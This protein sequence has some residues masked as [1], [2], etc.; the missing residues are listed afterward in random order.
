MR[1]FRR[2]FCTALVFFVVIIYSCSSAKNL[3]NE[4]SPEQKYRIW[5]RDTISKIKSPYTISE[6]SL[7]LTI[8]ETE[9]DTISDNNIMNCVNQHTHWDNLIED[10]K[11]FHL[12]INSKFV[13]NCKYSCRYV[14]T[15]ISS[16]KYDS[17]CG[18]DNIT[19][20]DDK[21]T[22]EFDENRGSINSVRVNY[23]NKYYIIELREDKDGLLKKDTVLCGSN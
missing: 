16:M 11:L 10:I 8:S 9:S 1:I 12:P 4:M 20:I 14:P 2:C 6:D 21:C 15:N 13:F 18:Y 3:K 5:L 19:L 23:S 7:C 22:Y 17:Y